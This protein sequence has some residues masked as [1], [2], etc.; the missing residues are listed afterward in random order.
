MTG[1]LFTS[2]IKNKM[3]IIVLTLIFIFS[4]DLKA[5]NYKGFDF[6]ESRV[7]ENQTLTLNGVG[8]REYLVFDV[9]HAGLYLPKSS[10]SAEDV[11]YKLRPVSILM[12]FVQDVK[13]EDTQ[14][15]WLHFLKIN[16]NELNIKVDIDYG[17]YLK[18]LPDLRKKDCL[19]HDF[20]NGRIIVTKNEEKLFQLESDNGPCYT[21]HETVNF[22]RMIGF[23]IRTTPS[24]S[25]ESNGMAEALVK[26]IKRD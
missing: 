25:P 4:L 26:T 17:L 6:S 19:R 7:L 21:S 22:G 1:R 12:C 14:K 24:Y 23:D 8:T 18:K 16:A 13:S 2:N 15:A 20:I 9:Y 11:L 10:Q 5:K 3:R